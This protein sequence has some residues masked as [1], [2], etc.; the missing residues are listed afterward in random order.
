MPVLNLQP[1]ADELA[2]LITAVPDDM[3]GRATPCPGYSLG[4]LIDHVG[5]L[6]LAFAAAA[7]KNIGPLTGPAPPWDAARLGPDWRT[8]IPRHLAALAEA[9]QDPSAWAGQTQAG[10]VDLAGEVAGLFA[11]DELVVH[12]WDLARA[13][14][15]RLDP[16]PDAVAALHEFLVQV[17]A[18]DPGGDGPFGP[19]VAVPADGHLLDRVVGLAGRDPG[20]RPPGS[21][22]AGGGR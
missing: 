10:G 18:G 17:R 11:L 12:G 20:W 2:E 21:A 7:A 6:A 15:Q 16:E 3:L 9:W 1:A 14:D 4:D 13:S 19:V 22:R 8:R 5:G